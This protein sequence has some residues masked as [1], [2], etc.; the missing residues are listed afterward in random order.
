[1]AGLPH[2]EAKGS[3]WMFSFRWSPLEAALS[4]FLTLAFFFVANSLFEKEL[5]KSR[6]IAII[7]EPQAF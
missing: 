4:F 6:E 2:A 1:L 7:A 5:I 3:T